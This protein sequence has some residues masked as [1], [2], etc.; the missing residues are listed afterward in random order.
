MAEY[1]LKGYAYAPLGVVVFS[2]F[3]VRPSYAKVAIVTLWFVSTLGPGPGHYLEGDH[4]YLLGWCVLWVI[5]V[6]LSGACNKKGV[7]LLTFLTLLSIICNY[8]IVH[9][10]FHAC[11]PFVL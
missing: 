4:P 11:T 1:H 5:R 9:H 8:A 3:S 10:S 6:P 2:C 7:Y